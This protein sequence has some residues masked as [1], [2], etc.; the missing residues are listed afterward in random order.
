M[1]EKEEFRKLIEELY[2]SQSFRQ[3]CKK[4]SD[5]T[6]ASLECIY[7]M[8]SPSSTNAVRKPFYL[9]LRLKKDVLKLRQESLKIQSKENLV[10]KNFERLDEKKADIKRLVHKIQIEIC[11]FNKK[12]VTTFEN[13]NKTLN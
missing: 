13:L 8:A 10:K 7:K 6:G 2:P 11:D 5:D 12:V 3:S 9:L 1:I 4:C